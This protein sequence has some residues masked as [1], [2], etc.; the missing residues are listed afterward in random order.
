MLTAL[1]QIGGLAYLLSVFVASKMQIRHG[2]VKGAVFVV[3]YFAATASA[4]VIA[5]VFGRVP[6][7]C[8]GQK[9]HSFA[10]Q[11]VIYCVL[12]RNYVRP[13][14]LDLVT[15]LADDVADAFPGTTTLVLDG[16]FP[17]LDGFPMLP[18]LSHSDGRKLDIAFYYKNAEGQFMDRVTRSP[19]GYFA[20]EQPPQNG[21]Q[22][23]QDRNDIVTMRW[24]LD[25]LQFLFPSYPLEERRMAYSLNWL[26][27]KGVEK[28]GLEKVLIEPHLRNS[29]GVTNNV[30]RFQGCRAARHDDHIHIQIK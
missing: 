15:T 8:M 2:L 11:S 19:I 29:L 25:W 14:M 13:T 26:A 16:N 10:V 20:F 28:F 23:C 3:I 24:N 6:I 17:F 5:P 27:T 4:T 22:P 9:N 18:H 21:E 7:P 30:I 12:N 1:T